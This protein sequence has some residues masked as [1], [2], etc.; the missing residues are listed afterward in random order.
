MRYRQTSY[1]HYGHRRRR[2]GRLLLEAIIAMALT[3]ALLTVAAGLAG[4]SSRAA[5]IS[6]DMLAVRADMAGRAEALRAADYVDLAAGVG[7]SEQIVELP[8]CRYRL[9]RAV[10]EVDAERPGLLA[11]ALDGVLLGPDDRP[12]GRH[13][14][15]FRKARRDWTP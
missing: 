11:I 15:E 10:G 4:E 13:V 2:P 1:P 12:L 7:R 3:G 8:G 6:R 5:R 14:I 9:V